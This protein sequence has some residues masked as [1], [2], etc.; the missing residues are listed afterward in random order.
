MPQKSVC[1]A[2][3]S[4]RLRQYLGVNAVNDLDED[5]SPEAGPDDVDAFTG[6]IREHQAGLRAFVRSLGVEADWVD[7]VAQEVFLIA[8]RQRSRF[9]SGKDFGRWLRGIARRVAANERRKEGRRSRLLSAALPELMP[10]EDAQVEELL[11]GGTAPILEAL[12]KCVE[13]L[14]ERGRALLGRR[15]EQGDAAPAL[16]LAFKLTPDAVRQS[17]VRLRLAVK[18]CVEDKLHKDSG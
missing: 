14:P 12:R 13:S 11:D 1:Y 6:L 7:D 5:T 16:A 18:R 3:H 17:L 8:Y 10:A 2:S 9:E 15:Y 4:R